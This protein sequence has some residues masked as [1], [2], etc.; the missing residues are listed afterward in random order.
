MRTLRGVSPEIASRNWNGRNALH[1]VPIRVKSGMSPQSS[2]TITRSQSFV[3]KGR[4]MI[5]VADYDHNGKTAIVPL[6]NVV[7]RPYHRCDCG[8][9]A[10]VRR[11]GGWSCD[12][13]IRKQNLHL[14]KNGKECGTS[15]ESEAAFSY[16][17]HAGSEEFCNACDRFMFQRGITT[18][19]ERTNDRIF[20]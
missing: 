15:A 4:V 13:C 1:S 8:Q 7:V 9:V 17:S 18:E 2:I 12:D 11:M 10:F 6:E 16:R 3:V 5:E 20:A 19:V 14:Q